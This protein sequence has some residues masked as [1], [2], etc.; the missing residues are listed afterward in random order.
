MKILVAEN[1][2]RTAQALMLVMEREDHQVSVASSVRD[3][4][5]KITASIPDAIILDLDLNDSDGLETLSRIKG[6]VGDI[7][8]IAYSAQHLWAREAMRLGADEFLLKGETSPLDVLHALVFIVNRRQLSRAM[9]KH[10][11][12][13]DGEFSY[14]GV[15]RGKF[16]GLGDRM[17]D[18]AHELRLLAD[19]GT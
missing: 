19:G 10:E 12:A 18:M 16:N 3:F 4:L 2:A 5:V 7:I 8:I 9:D 1:D 14:P 6:L 13:R 17:I 15:V 11:Q